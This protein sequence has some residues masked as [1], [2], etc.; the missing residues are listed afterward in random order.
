VFSGRA[1]QLGIQGVK[2][3]DSPERIVYNTD[4]LQ[5]RTQR[6]GLFLNELTLLANTVM[7]F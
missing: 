3:D 6:A 5:W 7:L 1:R 2:F 4:S